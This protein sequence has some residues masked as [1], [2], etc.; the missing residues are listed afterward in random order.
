MDGTSAIR[1]PEVC[2]RSKFCHCPQTGTYSVLGH[3]S[4]GVDIQ[5][6]LIH[7]QLAD[8]WECQMA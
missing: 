2:H 1:H 6:M 8:C 5:A 7:D 3:T 4:V